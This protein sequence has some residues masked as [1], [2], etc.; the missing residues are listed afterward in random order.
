MKTSLLVLALLVSVLLVAHAQ[1]GGAAAA[2]AAAAQNRPASGIP[3]VKPLAPLS[4]QEQY[5]IAQI[6]RQEKEIAAQK[7]AAQA[8][9]KQAEIDSA[10]TKLETERD[11]I[12]A[13]LKAKDAP[14]TSDL[15]S[16]IST[17]KQKT[18]DLKQQS[19]QLS[20]AKSQS[21]NEAAHLR[22]KQQFQPK[23]PWRLIDG[24]VY[25]AKDEAWVQFTGEILEVKPKGI[26]VRGDFGPPLEAGFGE[27]VF[28]V[29]NFPVQIYPWADGESVKSN[30]NFVAHYDEKA[31]LYRFTNSTIDLHVSTVRRLDYGKIVTSPPPD[32]A[33][34]W[35]QIIIASSGSQ[36]VTK[37][38]A[39]NQEQQA[40]VEKELAAITAKRAE[41]NSVFEKEKA[42]VIAEYKTKIQDV[43]IVLANEAKA[44]EVAK[45]QATVSAVVKFNQEQA[46]KGD[47][48]GLLRMGER[49]RN[50]DGVEKNLTKARDYLT[51]AAAAGSPTAADELKNLPEK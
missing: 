4:P 9:A 20:E 42:S 32:L 43:P 33:Q 19:A 31:P 13:Q 50:G 34:K 36:Q 40:E 35:N 7:A 12:I 21:D 22:A 23:D 8:A 48:F 26:L 14:N 38:L 3:G 25:N 10:V 29:D 18:S 11:G 17:L 2:A 47:V 49:Y 15:D 39:E 44:K 37:A 45:K 51:K 24:K 41:L 27:R 5:Q 30:M 16:Q 1:Y 46:D 6:Q 28:F